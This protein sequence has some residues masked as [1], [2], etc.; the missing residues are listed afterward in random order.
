MIISPR[1]QTASSAPIT[2]TSPFRRRRTVLLAASLVITGSLALP[3]LATADPTSPAPGKQLTAQQAQKLELQRRA[4]L[5]AEDAKTRAALLPGDEVKLDKTKLQNLRVSAVKPTSDGV[6]LT[7][8]SFIGK[9]RFVSADV[10]KV[11]IQAAGQ[12]D[13]KSVAVVKE[14]L[15]SVAITRKKTASQYTMKTPDLTVRIALRKFAV[16]M[17]DKNGKVI[18]ADDSRFG[19]GYQD[20]KPYVFKKTDKSE[21]FYGFGE[22]TKSLNKRGDSIG[23]W[24][25]DHY[26][27]ETDAKYIYVSIPFFTGLKGNRAYGIFF[28]NT[29]HSYYEMASESEDYYYFYAGG[30]ELNYYFIN[31]P[32]MGD[33]LNRYTQLTGRY[34]QPPEWSLGWE[35]SHWGYKPASK[36]VDVAKGY[37]ERK[38]PLDAMNMD[39]DYMNGWR[40]FTW[41]PAWGEPK[42]MD[43][44][45]EGMGV[46]TIAINDPGVKKE[47]GYWLSDQGTDRG[48][49]ATNPDGTNY[50]GA[51]WAGTS[52]FPDFTR[53]DV[54][55][56]WAD[57]FPKL[58]ND[59]GVDGMWLDMNEPAVFDGP[60]HTAPLDVQFD[61]GTKEHTE[62]HNIYGF[63]N[64]V[65]TYDG[66]KKIKPQERAFVFSRDMYAGSQR[67]AALWSGD[68]VSSWDH[69]KLTLPLNMNVGL[70]GVPHV[71][72]DIGGFAQDT[73]PELFARWIESGSFAPFARVH[74][75]N[76]FQPNQQ[77]QEPWCLGPE[78]EAIAKKYVSLRYSLLPYTSTAFHNSTVDGRPVQQ[79]LVYQFQDDPKVRNVSDQFMWG[80]DIM[81]APVVTKGATSREVYLPKGKDWIDWWTGTRYTGDQ[82]ITVTAPLDVMPIFVA[83]GAVIPTREVQQHTGENPFTNVAFNVFLGNGSSA[84]GTLYEDDGISE[85]YKSGE[86]NS[87]QT[88]VTR[89]ADGSIGTKINK[90]HS[91]YDSKLASYDLV[92]RGSDLGGLGA[93]N[94]LK[95]SSIRL[96]AGRSTSGVRVKKINAQDGTV[97]VSVPFSAGKATIAFEGK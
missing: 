8:G 67:Y 66:L 57:Q 61:H 37:R 83:Q 46:K 14:S 88:T 75:D 73:T 18:N 81:V 2:P 20:G 53:A 80:N 89:N 22:Q 86:W 47:K 87:Y 30:G 32:K 74:Y 21:A 55:A 25:T 95:T 69:L 92:L 41:D 49:W 56:W 33:V 7:M 50:D 40:V 58:V 54:R 64:T 23:M 71:G 1:R 43:A 79:A 26:S 97:T 17:L 38:I 51:V 85:K 96:D 11:T 12:P 70:S 62:V 48:Y 68:N 45:L 36:I 65:A 4:K 9:V 78:V 3:T 59:G 35:Q 5:A 63:W 77:C 27:Y 84:T 16:T 44:Q 60:N 72:N 10:V 15:G 19:S 31:G 42:Q 52:N 94:R 82:T 91:G 34:Q 90:T 29:H 39:V 93:L 28:D 76:N 13:Y 6:E 24:N